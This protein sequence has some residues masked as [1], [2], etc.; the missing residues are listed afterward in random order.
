M[1][2]KAI[3]LYTVALF[4][5][6]LTTGC[7]SPGDYPVVKTESELPTLQEKYFRRFRE[8]ELGMSLGQYLDVFPFTYKIEEQE[9]V[10]AYELADRQRYLTREDLLHQNLMYGVGT[11]E[12]RT[13]IRKIWF[14]FYNGELVKWG[15]P[16]DWPVFYDAPNKILNE[17]P[18]I[19]ISGPADK[20]PL[21]RT[22]PPPVAQPT[23]AQDTNTIAQEPAPNNQTPAAD[24]QP[25]TI[26]PQPVPQEPAQQPPVMQG[27]AQNN[28][29]QNTPSPIAN[30]NIPQPPPVTQSLPENTQEPDSSTEQKPSRSIF[31]TGFAVSE[32]GLIVTAFHNVRGARVVKVHLTDG[33]YTSAELVQTDPINDL[34][35]LKI[36]SSTP[37]FINISPMRSVKGGENAFTIG[38]AI[39][40]NGPEQRF[41]EGLIGPPAGPT[42]P[43]SLLRINVPIQPLYAGG[44]LVDRS[45]QAVGVITTKAAMAPLLQGFDEL[46]EHIH[47]AIKTDY[48]RALADLPTVEQELLEPAQIV[49]RAR[50]ATFLIEAQ[51]TDN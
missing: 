39:T 19:Q 21:P 40:E 10:I 32:D 38:F 49:N 6:L 44:A 23:P 2:K 42:Y 26:Q 27:T 4:V 20:T 15:R 3:I 43:A 1:T 5:G 24:T 13:A 18:N 28:Q 16:F 14:Y 34:A 17:Y 33:F 46:P 30:Q 41:A 8:I 29:A 36:K 47:L 9:G 51:Y 37:D 45:G 12:P 48:L 25:Q 7:A 31:G 11:P 50:A 35:V 22:P